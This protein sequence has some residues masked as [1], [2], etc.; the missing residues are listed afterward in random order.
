V[1]RVTLRTGEQVLIRP[2]R[3]DDG[4]RLRASYHRL[5]PESKYRRFL[6][7]KPELS[8][9]DTRYFVAVDAHDHVALVACPLDAPEMIV[10]VARFVRRR[11]D[12]GAAEFAIVVGDD[13]QRSGLGG[14]LLRSLAARARE[15]GIERFVGSILAENVAAHRLVAG[16]AAA[17]AQWRHTGTVD[18]VEFDLGAAPALLAA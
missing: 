1:E 11:E 17:P 15:Q 12:P 8:S 3:P 16:V 9:R 6:A 7:I 2:I 18:E 5:S 13:Y 10:A 14:A 4:E